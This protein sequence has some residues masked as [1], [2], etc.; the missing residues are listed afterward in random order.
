MTSSLLHAPVQVKKIVGFTAP[1]EF[2]LE[3]ETLAAAH[4]RLLRVDCIRAYHF[5]VRSA[6]SLALPSSKVLQADVRLTAA[7]S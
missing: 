2:I 7:I 4:S 3:V 1:P 6:A 5:G